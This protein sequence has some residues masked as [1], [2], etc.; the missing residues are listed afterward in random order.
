MGELGGIEGG[1][2][3][4]MWWGYDIGGY[5]KSYTLSFLSWDLNLLRIV[6]GK[7]GMGGCVQTGLA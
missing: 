3:L 7:W 1:M 4:M 6:W 5:V 2:W